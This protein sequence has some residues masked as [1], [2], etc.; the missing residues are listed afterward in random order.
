MEHRKE[1]LVK[2]GTWGV[3]R[4]G[5][6]W[7]KRVKNLFCP[8]MRDSFPA[9]PSALCGLTTIARGCSADHIAATLLITTLLTLCLRFS[10]CVREIRGGHTYVV[11]KGAIEQRHTCAEGCTDF[12]V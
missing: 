3:G 10:M 6:K 8:R 12:Q 9:N 5:L 1:N 11:C 7:E 2:D 4:G